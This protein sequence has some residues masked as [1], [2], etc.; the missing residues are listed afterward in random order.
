[1][2]NSNAK[3]ISLS[4]V[5][6]LFCSFRQGAKVGMVGLSAAVLL[7]SAALR[8]NAASSQMSMAADSFLSPSGSQLQ[9]A[10][11]FADQGLQAFG[12]GDRPRAVEHWQNALLLYKAGGDL[13]GEGRMLE[14]LSVIHRFNNEAT[15]A[16]ALSEQAI[17]LYESAGIANTQPSAYLNLG[18]AYRMAGDTERAIAAYLQGLDLYQGEKDIQGERMMLS[19]LAQIY[20]DRA[21]YAQTI[22]YQQQ[23][24]ALSRQIGNPAAEA[25]ALSELGYAYVMNDQ[26]TQAVAVLHLAVAIYQQM[27]N[28]PADCYERSLSQCNIAK[29][30]NILI[31]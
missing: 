21:D 28:R 13:A 23:A 3:Q 16:I 7:G 12:R 14:N 19:L 27:G 26:P 15:E 18:S 25:E 11:W 29:S 5:N 20:K 31:I 30:L 10:G 2:P 9:R 22:N 24:L 6:R 4:S 1:M 8:A 17:A